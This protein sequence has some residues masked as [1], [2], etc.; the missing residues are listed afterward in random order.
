MKF[1]EEKKKKE[2]EYSDKWF[3][4]RE[5]KREIE[6]KKNKVFGALYYHFLAD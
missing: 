1:I 2:E 3:Y 6:K 5:G 4:K